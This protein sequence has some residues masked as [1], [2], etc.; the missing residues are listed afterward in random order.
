MALDDAVQGPAKDCC[1]ERTLQLPSAR[2]VVSLARPFHLR[3]EPQALLC[4][5]RRLPLFPLVAGH[6]RKLRRCCSGHH[7][8]EF[9]ERRAD[10]EC[11]ERH[12]H[13]QRIAQ[14][15]DDLDGQQRI[16][17][18]LEETVI[19][20]DPIELE[21]VGP[22]GR[23]RDLD[24]VPRRLE[25]AIDEVLVPRRRQT[26]SVE[27]AVRR[28]GQ[29]GQSHERGRHH[30]FGH[31]IRDVSPQRVDIQL[32]GPGT[33]RDQSRVPRRVFPCKNGCLDDSRVLRQRRLDFAQFD[34]EAAY[35][36]LEV[37]APEELD[38]A[39]RQPPPEI[40]G[41]V[42]P[43]PG[44]GVER[45]GDEAF[46][47]QVGTVEVASRH[48]GAADVE[49]SSHAHRHRLSVRVKNIDTRIGDGATYGSTTVPIGDLLVGRTEH[50][51]FRRSV[52]VQDR[53]PRRGALKPVQ[54]GFGE[55]LHPDQEMPERQGLGRVFQQAL[56]VADKERRQITE[57]DP[58]QHE[59]VQKRRRIGSNG[60]GNDIER[61]ARRE[62]HEYLEYGYV[63][64]EAGPHRRLEW[65]VSAEVFE[66]GFPVENQVRDIPVFHHHGF[67]R[68]GGARRVDHIGQVA[69]CPV[70]AGR[71]GIGIRL[72]VQI[73]IQIESGHVVCPGA[74]ARPFL[75]KH[76][77]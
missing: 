10:E 28:Q 77:R 37:V 8:G 70:I 48:A 9:G 16:A 63:K 56:Q 6:R 51:G 72:I 64:A 45:I 32:F 13:V 61:P 23:D 73:E 12:V 7:L 18:E 62:R 53:Q 22:D 75:Q 38:G 11:P 21:Q 25:F 59:P 69:E 39:V 65:P 49:F 60:I 41:L 4:E 3:Q 19:P 54:V 14:A 27:F 24:I 76:L 30:V 5:G 58:I 68:A 2:D 66:S 52:P 29:P 43:P 71:A 50:G 67:W 34:A 20:S 44:F 55:R 15:R 46:L 31:S 1:I 35:L 47:R 17:A 57:I 33:V 36:H 42:H 40:A 74:G 26:L